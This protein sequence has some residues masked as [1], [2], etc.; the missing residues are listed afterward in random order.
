MGSKEPSAESHRRWRGVEVRH[1]ATLAAVAETGSFREAASRRGYVPSSVSQQISELERLVGDQLVERRRG[2]RQV[3]LTP[4]G[5]HLAERGRSVLASFEAAQVDLEAVS[6]DVTRIRLAIGRMLVE[7]LLPPIASS[8][9]ALA[10]IVLDVDER[11]DDDDPAR[12]TEAGLADLGVGAFPVADP[13]LEA[14]VLASDPYELV[15]RETAAGRSGRAALT[16]DRLAAMRLVI[17][18]GSRA[19]CEVTSR[20]DSLGVPRSHTLVAD[21]AEIATCV[22]AGSGVGVVTRSMR[23]S[24]E[25]GLTRLAAHHLLGT[26]VIAGMWHRRRRAGSEA[27]AQFLSAVPTIR[28]M[29]AARLR[30]DAGAIPMP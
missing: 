18:A 4:A 20:L 13:E 16:R 9:A 28:S 1:F 30:S 6:G 27:V 11:D 23:W 3:E 22:R 21:P 24:S 8:L 29:L 26:R 25:E 15:I 10:D 17:P 14:V 5:S 19:E 12:Q 7:A 2:Q